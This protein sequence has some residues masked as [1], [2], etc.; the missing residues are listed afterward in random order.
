MQGFL[1]CVWP[2]RL[3]FSVAKEEKKSLFDPIRGSHQGMGFPPNQA[4]VHVLLGIQFP[5]RKSHTH[6]LS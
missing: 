6:S 3:T 5:V 4:P 2:L 1:H